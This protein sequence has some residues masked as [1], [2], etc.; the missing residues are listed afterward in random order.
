MKTSSALST[1]CRNDHFALKRMFELFIL[2]GD[3]KREYVLAF[4][5]EGRHKKITDISHKVQT[6]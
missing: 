3:K 2:S 1:K 6:E 4:H 5:I